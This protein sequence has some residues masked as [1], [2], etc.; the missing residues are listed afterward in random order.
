MFKV[1]KVPVISREVIKFLDRIYF[2]N[3][4]QE[5]TF[6]FVLYFVECRLQPSSLQKGVCPLSLWYIY[7]VLVCFYR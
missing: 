2:F 4:C 3:N 1:E 6:Y 7:S 5:V